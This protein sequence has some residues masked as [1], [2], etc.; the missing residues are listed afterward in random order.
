MVSREFRNPTGYDKN[1]VSE[2]IKSTTKAT[3]LGEA[4]I[5]E[6]VIPS[7]ISRGNGAMVY[8]KVSGTAR[9][10]FLDLLLVDP[11]GLL[12]WFPNPENLDSIPD[13]GKL[14]L[15][16]V[17]EGRWGFLTTMDWKRGS[18]VAFVGLY[19]DTY[20]LPTINRRLIAYHQQLIEVV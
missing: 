18:Y 8:V 3:K 10:A 9:Y 15:D 19:E 17:Y 5:D 14:M 6:V 12:K 16:G 11:E 2:N 20:D 13:K 7:E 4:Q 1:L